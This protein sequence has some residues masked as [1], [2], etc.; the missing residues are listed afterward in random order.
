M[1][2][3]DLN[4]QQKEAVI[5]EGG[6]LLILAGA[7]SG[8][9]KVLTYRIA[10]LLE[11]GLAQPNEILSVTFT[12]KAAKE[13]K[14]RIAQIM[15]KSASSL[16][17]M[18]TFHSICVKILKNE[19]HYVGL[20]KKFTIYDIADQLDSIKEAMDKLMIS[21][22]DFN[23]NAIHSFI[24]SAKNELITA[25]EYPLHAEGY[26]QEV[27]AKVY[28]LY[29]KL[30]KE[31]NAVDFDDLIMK[32]VQLM[33]KEEKVL[34]KYQNLF[35]YILVDEYQD[36]NKAQYVLIYLLAKKN[37]Q[38][39]VVGDDDQSI[40]A[41]RGATIRN[42]LE[43]ERDF[44]NTKVIKL[45]QNYRST[46][47]ILDASYNV[48]SQ[49]RARKDKRLWTE[50]AKGDNVILYQGLDEKDE[51]YWVTDRIKTLVNDGISPE[52][53]V[54]LY[55]T[56]AQSRGMEEAFLRAGQPYRIIGNVRFYERKEIKDLMAYLRVIYNPK[57]D[58]SL[59]RIINV[60]RRGIGPK[61]ISETEELAYNQEKSLIEYIVGFDPNDE[62]I[63]LLA[64]EQNDDPNLPN[65][66]NKFRKLLIELY[67]QSAKLNVV[68]LMKIILEL[69]GYLDWLNDGTSENEARI[70][71]IK[72]LVSVAS[73]YQDMAPSESL[74]AFM[75]EVSL[76][77]QESKETDGDEEKV[78]LMTIHSAKGLEFDY[79]F[80]V[81]MEEGIFPHSRSYTD[82]TQLEE[83]R[84]LAY[85][86]I[87]R[88]KKK[89]FMTHAESR[90]FFGS[91]QNNLISRF[92][93]DI[94]EE[95]V[96]FETYNGNSMKS[97]GWSEV[98]EFND[99]Y[100]PKIEL[101]KGD[102]VLHPTFGKGVVIGI[103][104]EIIKIQFSGGVGV[105]EL[106]IE[107]AVLEKI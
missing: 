9:T 48:I 74:A 54:I 1:N 104:D 51:A 78:T 61:L 29:Q 43:F 57:D 50:N 3:E 96:D 13:M 105:K 24:S 58:L 88:A 85:V 94:P 97:S 34:E 87:T 7:G 100:R 80:L 31:N 71:N 72:E 12:N 79:V 62:N 26:F 6:P 93:E 37:Q 2:L 86:A 77:E 90:L 40:Y 36:T 81:G 99:D 23:P 30:L 95:L 55:R 32:T 20:D 82:T 67:K 63:D 39:T 76:I 17:W 91:R 15:G 5:H 68:Q 28:P 46:Q 92:A 38:L 102:P 84:R 103:N 83:E 18:G 16:S 27:V 59:K 75:D 14:I 56:N 4:P 73:K 11:K 45:E 33:Q 106:A 89:L 66:L 107:Y 8:K 60:P 65:N 49:N 25:E 41:F 22:K 19:G 64:L 70:E 101:Q 10:Y 42:I 52:E 21:K 98:D 53:I 69:S 47:K 44:P 35:K